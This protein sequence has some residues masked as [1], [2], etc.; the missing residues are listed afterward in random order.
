MK[1][2]DLTNQR[3]GKLVACKR[4]DATN[5]GH[6]VWLFKCDCGNEHKTDPS[7]VKQGKV[8]SCGCIRPEVARQNGKAGAEKVR[9]SKTKHGA[10]LPRSK[11]Y[12]QYAVW[13]SMRQRCMNKNSPDYPDYGA[14]GIKVCE[15]WDSFTAFISDMGQRPSDKHSIDRID[16]NG[17]YTPENCRW[18]TSSEQAYN[19]RSKSVDNY[20]QQGC[21]S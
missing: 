3:F 21:A 9:Q 17:N 14:R 16:N 15:R 7:R 4:L 6:A 19:R 2:L 11:N 20:N 5:H 13:K 8:I 10:A 12:D 1:A 18:A